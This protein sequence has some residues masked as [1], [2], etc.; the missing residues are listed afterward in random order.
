MCD[1]GD[2]A[3]AELVQQREHIGE[4]L[5]HG[6]PVSRRIGPAGAAE[7]RRE[8]AVALSERRDD[9]APLPPVLREPVQEQ[10]RRG[11]RLAGLGDV[12]P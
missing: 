10:D 5:L 6:V 12:H 1:E 2:P 7:V 4:D 9:L 8:H 11:I 3:E